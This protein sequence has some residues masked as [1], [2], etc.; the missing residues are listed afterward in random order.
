MAEGAMREVM[1]DY[2]I[3]ISEMADLLVRLSKEHV[4]ETPEIAMIVDTENE[5]TEIEI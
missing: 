2:S 1:V 5:K 3:P 4:A